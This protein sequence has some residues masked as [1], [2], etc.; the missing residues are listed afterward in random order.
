MDPVITKRI[1]R[2]GLGALLSLVAAVSVKA[3]TDVKFQIDMTSQPSATSVYVRGSFNGWGTGSQ[4]FN[5]GTGIYTNTFTISDAPGTIEQC[6]FYYDPGANWEGDPNR[7]FQLDSGSQTLPLTTWN[8]KYPAP[9]N[10]VTFQVDLSAQVLA[11]AFVPGQTITVSGDLTGWGDGFALTNNPNAAGLATNIY[12]GTTTA[13]GFLP[14][15][16]NYKFRANGGWESPSSTS[17]GNRQAS[18]TNVNQVLPL[19]YYNDLAPNAPTNN[20]TF[21]VDLTPQTVGGSFVPG[22][23]TI[24]VS[25]S[26][27]GWG[28]GTPLTNNPSLSGIASNVY[29]A[30]IPVVGYRP[31]GVQYKFRLDAGWESPTSTAGNNRS[32][33]I[34]NSTQVLPLVYYNDTTPN[35]ILLADTVVVFSLDMTNAVGTD[36]HVFDPNN[37]IVFINGDF[38]GWLSWNPLTLANANLN[39]VN[40]PPGSSI[41]KFTKTFPAGSQRAVTYKYSINGVDNEAGY[42]QDQTRYIRSVGG[43]TYNMP[44]DKFGNKFRESKA[45]GLNISPKSGGAFP[46][47]WLPYPSVN[48]QS[49]SS[50]SGPWTDVANTLGNSSTNW[51]AGS[52]SKYFRLIGQ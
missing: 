10:N 31:V 2:L 38:S 26:M 8:A 25:G 7:Q 20:V 35:D 30:V 50:L 48:L 44:V 37:D 43:A 18:I 12:S 51:P 32:S 33:T 49:A 16:I 22:T 3:A 1:S 23:S 40:D 47:S 5:D 36:S 39:L 27:T 6:K 15:T 29:S 45:Y 19:V 52:G 41:Y 24:T 21:R 4:L 34:T 17:G 42:G 13:S 28:D 11:G 46:I 9:N 14:T